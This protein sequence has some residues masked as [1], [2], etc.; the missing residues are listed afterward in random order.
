[1]E[2]QEPKEPIE[3]SIAMTETSARIRCANHSTLTYHRTVAEVKDC[4]AGRTIRPIDSEA[5][6]AER[7]ERHVVRVF[8]EPTDKQV[9]FILRLLQERNLDHGEA[10]ERRI[11]SHTRLAASEMIN[12]LKAIEIP[13]GRPAAAKP[14]SVDVE[15]GRYAL[16]ADGIV[17]FYKVDKVTEGKWAGRTFIKAQASD[18]MYPIRS[19]VERNRLLSE[20]AKDPKAAMILYGTELGACGHCGR[21]LTDEDSR[22]RGIGPICAAKL[23]Y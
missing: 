3:M 10:A 23:G 2:P 9:A 15:S 4:F 17:K 7:E 11:R 6:E 13:S 18:E 20:I 22:A 16:R 1:V 8:D 21:T 19:S 5:I 14:I 12:R